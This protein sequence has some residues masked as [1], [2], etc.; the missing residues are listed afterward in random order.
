[1]PSYH[2]LE[3]SQEK[4]SRANLQSY[5]NM[6]DRMVMRDIYRDNHVLKFCAKNHV[7]ETILPVSFSPYEHHLADEHV[8]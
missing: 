8:V 4:I 7:K 6:C 1:M 3:T 5:H 2:S